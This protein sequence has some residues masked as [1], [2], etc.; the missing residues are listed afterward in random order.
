M[1]PYQRDEERQGHANGFKN[2]TIRTRVGEI[3][4]DIPQVREGGFYPSALEKGMR[5]ERALVIALA[6][7]GSGSINQ[8]SK[9]DYRRSVV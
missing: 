5:S 6:E 7:I 8:K 3:K 1:G 2:K 4:F 9:S